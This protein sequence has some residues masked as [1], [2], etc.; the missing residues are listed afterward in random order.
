MWADEFS[1][2]GSFQSAQ[3]MLDVILFILSIGSSRI[4]STLHRTN[5]RFSLLLGMSKDANELMP[6]VNETTNVIERFEKR[7]TIRLHNLPHRATYI[8]IRRPS[9]GRFYVQLRSAI[10]D[11]C[12]GF[13]DPTPG[14]CVG[15]KESYAL[16]AERELEEEMGID[17][18]MAELTRLFTFH[19]KDQRTNCWGEVFEC[20]FECEDPN[21]QLNIQES[22]V[23]EVFMM[24]EAELEAV[25]AQVTP[26]GMHALRL[27][28]RFK[29]KP[30]TILFDLDDC[31]Y[32]DEW[33]IADILTNNIEKWCTQEKNMK[34]GHAYALYKEYGT[35]LRGMQETGLINSE[36]ELE[37][38]LKIVHLIPDLKTKLKPN[39]LLRN[40]L[41]RIDPKI[42]K[43]IFTASVAAHA[44]RCLECLGIRDLFDDAHIIDTK[45]CKYATKHSQIAFDSAM[46]IC[47]VYDP[48]SI[49]FFDDSVRNIDQANATG[50]RGV[51]VGLTQRDNRSL[52]K[53]CSTADRKIDLI[54]DMEVN[55]PEL[56]LN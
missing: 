49:L 35:A 52:K 43:Y 41:L 38:Y 30:K 4:T 45:S 55:F 13:L 2:F 25:S 28:K 26:D 46:K 14:G 20:E 27:Y 7:S 56:F 10:K 36:D 48:T 53:I 29:Q 42:S 8:F 54:T 17:S 1:L 33:K 40:Q 12:P 9:D 3:K 37:E 39:D 21:K 24:N 32:F 47:G 22:E 31:L 11:Y 23:S 19:Y 5:L 34:P 16:N 50:I 6:V 44:V 18:K 15:E 51:L